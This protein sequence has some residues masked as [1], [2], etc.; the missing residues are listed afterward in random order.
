V[1]R[2]PIAALSPTEFAS[3]RS[4]ATGIIHA[5]PPQHIDLLLK[6][7]LIEVGGFNGFVLTDHGRRRLP[8]QDAHAWLEPPHRSR[9]TRTY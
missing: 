5:I 3:L 2:S 1:Q 9:D 7:E 4:I 6:M 8:L